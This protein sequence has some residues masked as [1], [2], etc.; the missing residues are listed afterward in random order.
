MIMENLKFG[1]YLVAHRGTLL[2]EM[3]LLHDYFDFFFVHG[4][5]YYFCLEGSMQG[6][7][8]PN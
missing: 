7:I 2:V 4:E 5:K 8:K 1:T 6:E 3:G